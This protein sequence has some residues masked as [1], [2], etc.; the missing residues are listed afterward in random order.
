MMCQ[1]VDKCRHVTL[2]QETTETQQGRRTIAGAHMASGLRFNEH[3]NTQ[4]QSAWFLLVCSTCEFDGSSTGK[5]QGESEL[6]NAVRSRPAQAIKG[7]RGPKRE[8]TRH[9]QTF[10]SPQLT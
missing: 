7:S 5:R 10:F 8:V 2:V 3:N 4:S 9:C 1:Q 6:K